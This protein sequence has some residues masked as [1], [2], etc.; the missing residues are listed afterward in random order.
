M[1]KLTRTS[2]IAVFLLALAG[3]KQA[4]AQTTASGSSSLTIGTVLYI[5]VSNLTVGF[6]SVANTDY[7]N[8]Y[9]IASALSQIT[10]K[11]NTTHTVSIKANASTMTGT[12]TGARASKPASDLQVRTR[13]SGGSYGSLMGLTTSNQNLIVSRAAGDYSASLY[14]V[15]YRMLLNW[16]NDTP[17]TYTLSFTYTIVAG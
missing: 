16:G 11:G 8:G 10:T 1:K 14:D 4:S 17:G 3:A 12:G 9:V 7:D 6:P 2:I 15:E 5:S 13:P